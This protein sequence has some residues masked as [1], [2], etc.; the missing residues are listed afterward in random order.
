MSTRRHARACPHACTTARP[1]A[2]PVSESPALSSARGALAGPFQQESS[3]KVRGSFLKLAPEMRARALIAVCWLLGQ[4]SL[5]REGAELE[6][7]D[8]CR[9]SSPRGWLR[10]LLP[11]N[12]SIV[13]AQ[14]LLVVRNHVGAE[15]RGRGI[16]L[17][18][19]EREWLSLETLRR[20]VQLPL[21]SSLQPGWHM[22]RVS[23]GEGQDNTDPPPTQETACVWSVSN[24]TLLGCPHASAPDNNIYSCTEH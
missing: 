7:R 11:L 15:S 3:L 16:A 20:V 22:V 8:G 13:G 17:A 9:M 1:H 18:I 14:S 2:P 21:P 6:T 12:A 5:A 4:L 24:L 19:D 23:A 10:V